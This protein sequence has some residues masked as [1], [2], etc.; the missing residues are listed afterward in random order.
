MAL[1]GKG[2]GHIAKGRVNPARGVFRKSLPKGREEGLPDG[3]ER[4]RRK[5]SCLGLGRK[6]RQGREKRSTSTEKGRSL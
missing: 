4:R 3:K 6:V 5:G 2:G 1:T